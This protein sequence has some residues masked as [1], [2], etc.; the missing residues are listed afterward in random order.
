M[1]SFPLDELAKLDEEARIEMRLGLLD[2][3]W[4]PGADDPIPGLGKI[5]DIMIEQSRATKSD[6]VL[7][8]ER[9]Q[10]ATGSR[11]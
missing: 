6:E 10:L 4:D 5:Y 8:G 11:P 9:R 7:A 3:R 1:P 2:N